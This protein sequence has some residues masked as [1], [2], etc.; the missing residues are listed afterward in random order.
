M[1]P[2]VRQLIAIGR[3]PYLERIVM[4]A[5]DFPDIDTTFERRLAL[6]L[7]GLAASMQRRTTPPRPSA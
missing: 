6:V 3:H 4:E 7:E 5:E 2:Y 1:G